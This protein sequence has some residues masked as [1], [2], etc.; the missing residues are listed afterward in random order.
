M[1]ELHGL[2]LIARKKFED[3]LELASIKP[4]LHIS[5]TAG[6]KRRRAGNAGF[7]FPDRIE[8][9]ESLSAS[10]SLHVPMGKSA[11]NRIAQENQQLDLRIV[12]PNPLH[13]CFELHVSRSSDATDLELQSE[14]QVADSP[15]QSG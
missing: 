5:K 9:I 4:P 13:R 10:V 6:F 12:I 15:A 7:F 2:D 14:D 11:L 3:P 8:K 1:F